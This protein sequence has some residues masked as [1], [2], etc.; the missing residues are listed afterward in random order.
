MAVIVLAVLASLSIAM[1]VFS[2]FSLAKSENGLAVQR[3]QLA[4]ESGLDFTGQLLGQCSVSP[5]ATGSALADSLAAE[6]QA[7]LDGSG[8]L[9][10]A[11]IVYADGSICIPQISL[12][13]TM[14]FQAQITVPQRRVIHVTV[15]G[16]DQQGHQVARTVRM[17]YTTTFQLDS[18]MLSKGPIVI[19]NEMSLLSVGNDYD[20]S[21]TSMASGDAI[22]FSGDSTISG[23]LSLTDPLAKVVTTATLTVGGTIAKGVEDV[24]F[25][26]FDTSELLA[27]PLTTISSSTLEGTSYSNIRIKAG[28]NPVFDTAVAIKGVMYVESPNVVTFDGATTLAGAIITETPPETANPAEHKIVFDCD[29]AFQEPS[30]LPDEPK[31]AAVR[32]LSGSYILAEGF[33]V[34]TVNNAEGP[35]GVL[36]ADQIYTQNRIRSKLYG[37]I[38][39]YDTG[40]IFISDDSAV[41]V[42][43]ANWNAGKLIDNQLV[44]LPD[45]YEE[46]TAP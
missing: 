30:T 31:Y 34:R 24:G 35:I 4:A 27:V 16:Y 21:M 39:A 1:I 42:D 23:D 14:S 5:G 38:M 18:A 13:G 8:N 2:G 36:A 26:E 33:S 44:P 3:A 20:A 43:R 37:A 9:S 17:N 28:T 10:G 41:T 12:G 15:T 22:S 29:I 7:L 11:A 32:R 19:N 25:P 46:V 45:T 6:L 40:G